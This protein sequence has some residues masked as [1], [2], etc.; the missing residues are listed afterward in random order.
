MPDQ[1]PAQEREP[2]GHRT[3]V[4]G[5]ERCVMTAGQPDKLAEWRA[6]NCA[7]GR[8]REHRAVVV[9]SDDEE[10]AGDAWGMPG[11]AGRPAHC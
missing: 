7:G 6:Q 2:R 10:W 3:L 1:V 9:A 11:G 5:E 8:R 4:L